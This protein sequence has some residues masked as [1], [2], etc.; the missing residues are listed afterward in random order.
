MAALG[1]AIARLGRPVI[2]VDLDPANAL[3]MAV[4]A[5]PAPATGLGTGM[6]R[7]EDWSTA[8]LATA[9]GL[10]LLPFGRLGAGE[11]LALEQQLHARPQWLAE[12]LGRIALADDA[13]MLIDTPRRPSILA[14]AACRAADR[15]LDVLTPAPQSWAGLADAPAARHLTAVLNDFDATSTLHVDLRAL[16]VDTLGRQLAPYVVHRDATVAEALAADR[17]VL[18]YLAASQA[19]RDLHALA[20]WLLDD[21]AAAA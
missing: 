6:A 16:Y 9:E 15:V 21:A 14:T 20:R 12:Q 5:G 13:V 8:A 2:V 7:G 11:C 18:D 1:L 4:G 17:P 10:T 3:G 19:V